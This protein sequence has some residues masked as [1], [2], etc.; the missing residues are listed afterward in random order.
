MASQ[1]S[2][3]ERKRKKNYFRVVWENVIVTPSYTVL[4][5]AKCKHVGA[6]GR[7]RHIIHETHVCRTRQ[8]VFAKRNKKFKTNREDNNI[9]VLI[10]ISIRTPYVPIQTTTT[11]RFSFRVSFVRKKL[12]AAESIC[13]VKLATE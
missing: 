5:N 2:S 12:G 10:R 13:I 4:Y 3:G 7:F 6:S 9:K 1:T 11:N 8:I